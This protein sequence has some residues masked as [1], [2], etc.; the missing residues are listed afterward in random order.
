MGSGDPR[1]SGVQYGVNIAVLSKATNGSWGKIAV[2]NAKSLGK[3]T[4][5][6]YPTSVKRGGLVKY[7][8]TIKNL[9]PAPQRFK[10]TDP[11][12]ANTT[13]AEGKFYNRTQNSIVWSKKLAPYGSTV[14]TFWVKVKSTPRTAR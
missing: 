6:A 8:L 1:D 11:I 9:G 13:F 7:T 10:V 3:V 2:W 5:K 4:L 14:L 12:P